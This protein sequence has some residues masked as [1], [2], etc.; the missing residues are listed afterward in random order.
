MLDATTTH[1]AEE[2]TP[3]IPEQ[4]GAAPAQHQNAE[5]HTQPAET[6]EQPTGTVQ[7][8]GATQQQAA[9]QP[10]PEQQADG[11][12]LPAPEATAVPA[13]QVPAEQVPAE[14]A[15]E[16]AG[17]P[18]DPRGGPDP[19]RTA[20]SFEELAQTWWT[21]VAGVHQVLM[22]EADIDSVGAAFGDELRARWEYAKTLHERGYQ[23]PDY[24]AERATVA[25]LWPQPQPPVHRSQLVKA[26]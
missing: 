18:A 22:E 20:P 23:V 8:T 1:T 5:Q 7:P 26:A 13:E 21:A 15:P 4:A 12:V 25:P 6:A 9:Q 3:A 16:A 17:S 24:L 2:T 11:T 14:H 19:I 10:A